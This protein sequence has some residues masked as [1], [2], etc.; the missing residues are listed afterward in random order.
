MSGAAKSS[1]EE[2]QLA[3]SSAVL[4][5]IEKD[6]LLAVTHSKVARHAKVSRAWLY[7]YIGKEKSTLIDHA[8]DV[9]AS[10]FSRAKKMDLPKTL[11]ELEQRLNEGVDFLLD[12][13]QM[14]PLIIKLYFRYRG[15]ENPIGKVIQKYEKEWLKSAAR[16]L[17]DVLKLDAEKAVLLAELMLTLRMSFAHR[18]A[19]SE[20]PEEFRERAKE[21]FGFIHALVGSIS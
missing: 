7:E 21:I 6:G 11:S 20:R 10:H 13:A 19:T 1:K 12:S 2:K 14:N 16:S 18:Q 3:V 17:V 8:A 4:Q 9:F 5:I 15:T